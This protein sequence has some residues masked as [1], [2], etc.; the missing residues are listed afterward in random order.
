MWF[1]RSIVLA[2]I[3][4]S[5]AFADEKPDSLTVSQITQINGAVQSMSC[6][7]KVLKD[8]AK[9]TLACVPYGSDRLR[10]GLVWQIAEIQTKTTAIVMQNHLV[11]SRPCSQGRRQP[12]RCRSRQV[13]GRRRGIVRPAGSDIAASFQACGDRSIEPAA[14]DHCGVDA[15]HRSV[16]NIFDVRSV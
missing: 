13:R 9:E 16:T 11:E 14:G 7:S 4:S 15:D 6:E 8:G 1:V 3:L 10:V 2:L 12:D 5:S